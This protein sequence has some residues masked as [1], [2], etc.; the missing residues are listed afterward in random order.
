M[1]KMM[2]PAKLAIA[3]GPSISDGQRPLAAGP[4]PQTRITYPGDL[5]KDGVWVQ[6]SVAQSRHELHIDSLQRYCSR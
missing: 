1:V 3:I 6:H 4:G 2:R 5:V